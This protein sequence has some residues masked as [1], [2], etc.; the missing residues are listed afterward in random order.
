MSGAPPFRDHFS[1]HAGAYARARPTYPRALF[2]RLA[3]LAPGRARAWDA[4]TGN[5]QAAVALAAHFDT[6]VAT[7]PSAPQIASAVRHR[8]VTYAVATAE[9]SGLATASCD[10]VTVAQALHWF[11]VPRFWDEA[12]RVLRPD[13]IVAVWTYARLRAAPAVEAVVDVLEDEVRP[14][15]PPERAHVDSG[16]A[17]L[18]FPF[19]AVPCDAPPM[20]VRWS[21]RALLDYLR[22]WS[23]VRR[24]AAAHGRDAVDAIE[25]PL[26]AAWGRAARRTICW[27]LAIRVG[28]VPG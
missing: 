20:T 4:G 8:R 15:W 9:S 27:P 1:G 6:V 25:A 5:G 19:A 17:T 11:D 26:A 22:T 14:W 7:D 2:T 16:Y 10:L 18:A 21:R 23:A 12:R 13:G 3:A 24:H 28:R